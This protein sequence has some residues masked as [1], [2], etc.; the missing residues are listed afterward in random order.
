MPDLELDDSNGTQ[1]FEFEQQAVTTDVHL[2]P[3]SEKSSLHGIVRYSIVR[4]KFRC[5]HTAALNSENGEVFVFG[6][7]IP[8]EV[9]AGDVQRLVPP[10]EKTVELEGF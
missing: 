8:G 4:N 5:G 9:L 3:K 1:Q 7:R 6:G 2:C 10:Q